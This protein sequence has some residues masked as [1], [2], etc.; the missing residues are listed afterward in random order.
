[1]NFVVWAEFVSIFGAFSWICIDFW[2]VQLDLYQNLVRSAGFV[3]K[4]DGYVYSHE[5]DR[6][7]RK[8]RRPVNSLC[9][10]V[11]PNRNWDAHFAELGASQ[12]QCS[13]TY[14]GPAPFSEPETKSLS[15]FIANVPRMTTYFSFHAYSQILL[16]PYIM[17][18]QKSI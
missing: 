16:L 6:D 14:P 3:S 13:L 1:M 7:W 10:G 5:K 11:D 2:C 15:D 8:N 4:F 12:V 9:Y 18:I 17:A